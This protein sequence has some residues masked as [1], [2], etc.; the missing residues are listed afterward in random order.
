[1]A[2]LRFHYAKLSKMEKGNNNKY[3]ITA[4]ALF[5][6]AGVFYIA[7][8]NKEEKIEYNAPSPEQV[9]N[10]YFTA[11]NNKNYPDMYAAIS[12][13]FKKIELTAKDLRAFKSYAESQRID[14]IKI[15]SIKEI[16]N[17]G[18]TA[19]VEYSIE[20]LL[21]EGKKSRFD[22]TFT[23]KYRKGDVIPGWK[24]IHPYGENIDT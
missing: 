3:L 16:S 9:V 12:D 22:G 13:G 15:L 24:L 2:N 6:V 23:L 20:F 5:F 10:Q 7:F 19:A 11:W 14:S 17:D 18:K 4:F 8:F 21:S 1:M